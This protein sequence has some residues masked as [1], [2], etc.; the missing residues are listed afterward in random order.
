MLKQAFD[1]DQLQQYVDAVRVQLGAPGLQ[2]AVAQAAAVA[3]VDGA[4]GDPVATLRSALPDVTGGIAS[5]GG[6]Q[7]TKV[8][9]LSRDPIQSL[10]QSTIEEKLRQTGVRDQTPA[11]RDLFATIVHAVQSLL[12][13]RRFGPTDLD[14]VI[15]V[16]KSMLDRLAAGN[17]PFNPSPARHEIADTSRIVV[18]GD[19]GTGLPRARAVAGFMAE[20]VAGALADGRQVHVI[21]LGDVYYSGTP[22]EVDRHVLAPGLWPVTVDQAR[23]GVTSW[24]LNGNHDMYGGGYGYYD[25]LLADERF[26]AQ[27]SPDDKPTSVF[28]LV[29]P[30]WQFVGLDTSWDTD[31]LAQG[32]KGVL[33][34]PQ[35]DVA[36]QAA[37]EARAAGRK[38]IL[39]SHHQLVSVYDTA[40]IG[41]VL[42][43]K[44]RPILNG[45]SVTAWLWGHEHRCMGFKPVSGVKFA[46]CIG[47][48]GVPVLMEHP[49]A[50]PIPSPGEWEERAFV[51]QGGD[52]WQR[53]GFAVL[54]M[55]SDRIDVRYRDDL[56]RQTR[57]ETIA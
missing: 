57:A 10:L 14:W 51:V 56:G 33:E 9:Y 46:R 50:A 8:P 37:A 1:R 41:T 38:L 24:S 32:H 34:D 20:E 29:A 36:A 35:A 54:D 31:V 48:G 28:G 7:T 3:G 23:H 27:R 21:H 13:P 45:D 5:S 25:R 52:R 12:H 49:A 39:L 6:R 26:S 30:S 11:G 42:P 19:W 47:H 22:E 2:G 15:D 4:G 44:L 53:F 18:V 16:G 40:D 17:H 43:S 55:A